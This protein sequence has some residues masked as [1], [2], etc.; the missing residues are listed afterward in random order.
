MAWRRAELSSATR[1]LTQAA[2]ANAKKT[3]ASTTH[4]RSHPVTVGQDQESRHPQQT[5][6]PA[7]PKPWCR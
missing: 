6:R 1:G 3:T 4:R 2:T 7:P 5:S